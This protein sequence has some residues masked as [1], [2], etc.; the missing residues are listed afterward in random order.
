MRAMSPR[1]SVPYQLGAVLL[2]DAPGAHDPAAAE[3]LLAERIPRV[4]RL[5][6]RLVRPPPGAGTAL[7]LDDADFDVRRHLHC[8]RCPRPGDERALLD[9]AATAVGRPLPWDRPLWSATVVT[10]LADGRMAL[11][12]VLHHVLVD[13]IGGLAVLR[14]LVDPA[15]GRSTSDRPFPQARPTY[16]QLLG[17]AARAR[18]RALRSVPSAVRGLRRSAR[19]GGGLH[20]PRAA[21]CAL[22]GPTGTRN[23]LDVVRV[24]LTDLHAAAHRVGATVNDALLAAVAGA[25]GSV[26]AD[27]GEQLETLVTA[28]MVA[29]RASVSSD[30]LGNVALPVVVPVPTGGDGR[31][32]LRR[33]AGTVRAARPPTGD[34]SMTAALGP[35]FRGLAVAGAYHWYIGRQRR[36]HT[37]VSNVHGPD[38]RLAFGGVPIGAVV[39]VSVGDSGNV[40]VSFLALSYAGTLTVTV[41]GDPDTLPEL[42]LIATAL[43]REFT[44][45][46]GAPV[47]AGG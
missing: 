12:L 8:A 35:L 5:R 27:R 28:V 7:W 44:A 46:T 23:R 45:L 33:I 30:E 43:R 11:L 22:L 14:R 19:A 29:G 1:A 10:G 25:L 13:G 3:Q 40:R 6:Q 32:R 17:D 41:I 38:R 18:L 2:L 4:P 37:L 34:P 42:P 31:S 15:D 39:P 9:L 47:P 16:R 36:F 24:D 26:L 20:P 21:R